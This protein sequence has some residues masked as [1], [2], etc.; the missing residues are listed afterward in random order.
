MCAFF[1]AIK[2]NLPRASVLRSLADDPFKY[3]IREAAGRTKLFDFELDPT[4][5]RPSSITKHAD[6]MEFV[7]LANLS[8]RH[9]A[10]A[11]FTVAC[12]CEL[13][14]D[15]LLVSDLHSTRHVLYADD[16]PPVNQFDVI[17]IANAKVAR[18]L[19]TRHAK[20]IILVG[21]C[22]DVTRCNYS[23]DETPGECCVYIDGRNGPVCDFHWVKSV[24][25][26]R[27]ARLLGADR[28]RLDRSPASSPERIARLQETEAASKYIE[29]HP[30][31]RAAKLIKAL[32]RVDRPTIVAGCSV[33]NVIPLTGK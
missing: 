20:Q 14:A 26:A 5:V 30:Y 25:G 1:E 8:P 28:G 16:H 17:A 7:P 12:I 24:D 22:T 4:F 27:C 31:G 19:T 15:W 13:H 29:K 11:Y 32:D 2:Q 33:G 21:S 6:H 10:R 9:S 18:E 23:G 3:V